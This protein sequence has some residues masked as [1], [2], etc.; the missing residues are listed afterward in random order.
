MGNDQKTEI[1]M[2]LK[3]LTCV[4]FCIVFTAFA[5]DALAQVRKKVTVKK[6][7]AAAPIVTKPP[8]PPFAT[9]QEIED[10]KALIAKLDCLACHKAEVKVVGPAYI[11]VA[12]KYPQNEN[13]LNMLSQKIING[14]SGVWGAVPMAP[15]P[16]IAPTDA[17]KMIKYI[18]T[19]NSKN[20]TVS[21]K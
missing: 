18:L 10:G 2:E 13:S 9:A 16:A 14:G 12:E 5:G 7:I 3:K 6:K 8:V 17:G 11:A 1:G 19:L 20:T 15:H 4:I 21:S